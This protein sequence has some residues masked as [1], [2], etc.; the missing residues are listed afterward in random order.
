MNILNKIIEHKKGE[1]A[2][3]KNLVSVHELQQ[4]ENF[5]RQVIS[6]KRF[7]LDESKTGIIAE[8]KEDRH[9]KGS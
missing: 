1:V 3:N 6:L 9:Q 5:H 2:R 7:L 8:F 4:H